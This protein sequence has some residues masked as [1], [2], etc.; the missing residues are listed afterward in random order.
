MQVSFAIP[1]LSFGFRPFYLGAAVFAALAVPLWAWVWLG[2][3]GLPGDTAPFSWH[4]HEMLFG[5]AVAVIAGFLLT[6]ARTWTGQPMP[7]GLELA[8][9]FA[10]WAAARVCLLLGVQPLGVWL[11]LLFLPVLAARLAVPLWRARNLRNAFVVVVLGMLA[12]ANALYHAVQHGLLAVAFAP[13]A[14]AAALG[15]LALLMTVIGGRIIPAFSANAIAGLK[16]RRWWWLDVV[17]I[18]ALVLLIAADL[19]APWLDGSGAPALAALL[20]IAAT[21]QLVRLWGWQPWRMAGQPLL[22]IL[23]LSYLWIPAHLAL[24]AWLGATPGIVPSPAVHA[25]TIGAMGGLML[26]MMTRSAL[27][28]TGRPLRAGRAEIVCFVAIHAAALCRVLGALGVGGDA[29]VWLG[30]SALLWSLAFATFAVAYLP[31]LTRP[32]VDAS[33]AGG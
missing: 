9:L 2:G 8:G 24:R 26:G 1:F 19:A 4:V 25:L 15:V 14:V 32:R 10:L 28:H 27:G 3:G 23:P 18:G 17:A 7:V 16:P 5:F 6:A 12:L 21:A 11:D 20:W 22:L 29:A 30:A 31:V 13:A 33:A